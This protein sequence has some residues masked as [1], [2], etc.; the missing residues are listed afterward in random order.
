VNAIKGLGEEVDE[1]II[2]QKV[3]RSLPMRFDPKISTLEERT[4]LDSISMDELHGIFTAYEM[5]TEQENLVTKEATFKASKKTKKKS[6]QN[7]KSECSCSDDSEEDEE[8]E[9]FVRK[10]QKGTCKYKGKLLLKCFNCGKIGHFANKCPYARNSDSDEEEEPK[11]EKRYQK[12]NWKN[13]KKSFKKNLYSRKDSSSSSE[14]DETDSD[15]EKVL[16]MAK[17]NQTRNSDSSEEEGKV[18]LREELISALEEL[19]KE[20][21]KNKLLKKELNETQNLNSEEVNQIITKLKVQVEEDRR[22]EE[23][24]RSQLAEKEKM[25]ERL[26]AEAITLRKYLQ[27]KDMQQDS[28]KTLDKII[29]NQRPYYDRSGLGYNQ[30]QTEKGSSSMMKATKQKSYAEVLK[31]RNHGQQESERNEYKRPSTFKQQGSFNH[32]ERNNQSEDL[33]KPRKNYRRTTPQ[34]KSFTPR[35]V[36]LFYGHC[37]YCTNFGHKVADCRAYERNNQARN[38]YVAPQNIECYKCHNYGHIARNCRSMIRPP[39]KENIDERHKKVWR[40][41]EKQ[42]EQVNEE[43]VQGIILSGFAVAQDHDEFTGK[44]ESV[45]IQVEDEEDVK[46]QDDDK[47]QEE[48]EKEDVFTDEEEDYTASEHV[49]F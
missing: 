35:Y 24:L 1:S 15:S 18:D 26:E 33:D 43:Q 41:S 7:P 5:R 30:M 2:V 44:E 12:G 23:I 25:I 13:K 29:N 40:R 37:F 19:R 36:N 49:L 20:R 28:T 27:K 31:G 22:I 8:M 34:G 46:T 47:I 16:F 3:L 11:K 9:N 48:D 4:D 39:M 10:L 6:K 32:C 17:E 14:D 42:E 45:G 21:K 38:A